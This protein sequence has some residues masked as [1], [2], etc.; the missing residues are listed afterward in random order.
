MIYSAAHSIDELLVNKILT[1]RP[2]HPIKAL[3][4]GLY[5]EMNIALKEYLKQL[6]P[7]T[8]EA[9]K[10][11]ILSLD[12]ILY[13]EN[14]E[15]RMIFWSGLNNELTDA[16]GPGTLHKL[17]R[18]PFLFEYRSNLRYDSDLPPLCIGPGEDAIGQ[19]RAFCLRYPPSLLTISSQ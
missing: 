18:C 16:N 13:G 2:S 9:F 6:H 10:L 19:L 5:D 3:I 8:Y 4:I 11:N 17:L 14:T 1:Y 7:A 15:Q 12:S